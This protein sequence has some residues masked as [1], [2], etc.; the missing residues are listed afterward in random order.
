MEQAIFPHDGSVQKLKFD[1]TASE[2][3]SGD[4][5]NDM[6]IKK[7]GVWE[8]ASIEDSTVSD[9]E[10]GVSGGTCVQRSLFDGGFV[11]LVEGDRVHD[12]IQRRFILSL[13][14][15]G[16]Q[17]QVV[18]IH[19]NACSSVMSQARV[20]SFRLYL[21]AMQKRRSGNANLKYAWYGTSG[22]QEVG[23]IISH[24]FGHC[25]KS[26]NN[27]KLYGCGLYLSPDDSPLDSVKSCAVDKDGL[28]HL[29]LCRVIL[30]RTELVHPGSEQCHPSAEEYD[31]GV[32]NLSAPTKY[33]IWCSRMNTHVLPEYVISFRIPQGSVKTEEPARRPSSP[34]MPF[35][36][37][38]SVLSKFLPPADIA[39]ISKHHK[40]HRANKI[41]RHDLIQKVRQV[42]GDKL[43]IGVIKSFREKVHRKRGRACRSKGGQRMGQ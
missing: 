20:Q 16:A 7:S 43:L 18:A 12:L 38:I 28:R 24:G 21:Q 13:G 25:G 29:L 33:V 22:K 4:W 17:T 30:G 5:S 11:R 2:Q 41:S 26:Q 8:P 19:R 32:D 23:E 31:S 1:D 27:N 10:S 35:P 15:P 37:L 39:L 40:D 42:A 3:D 6:N 34:W 36:T 14:L 9:C